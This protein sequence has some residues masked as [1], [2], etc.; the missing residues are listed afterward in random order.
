MGLS[1]SSVLLCC[2][3]FCTGDVLVLEYASVV[4]PEIMYG[5]ITSIALLM[6]ASAV[7]NFCVLYE[8]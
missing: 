7:L 1:V 2:V 3:W 8:A 6:S 5:V 4:L